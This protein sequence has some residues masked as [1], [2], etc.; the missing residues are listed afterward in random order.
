MKDT[1]KNKEYK[2]LISLLAL[3][4]TDKSQDVLKQNGIE[5]AQ[6]YE[7]LEYKLAKLYSKAE[8]KVALEK[9][10]AEIHPHSKFILKYLGKKPYGVEDIEQRPEDAQ[11]MSTETTPPKIVELTS[12]A[13]G[14]MLCTC[15]MCTQAMSNAE[16][17]DVKKELKIDYTKIAIVGIV[18]IFGMVL[19]YR[20]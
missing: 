1:S 2:S 4:S 13:N 14:N 19:L 9:K 10:F 6:S 11:A 15:P 20:K 18:A 17:D 5:P 8:D 12:N 3:G 7:E 16:G